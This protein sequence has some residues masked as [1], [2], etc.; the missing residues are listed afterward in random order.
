MSIDGPLD[1]GYANRTTMEGRPANVEVVGRLRLDAALWTPP[2]P[3]RPGQNGRPRKRG[4]RLLTPQ[5]QAAGRTRRGTWHRLRVGL[6]GR[7][8]TPLV[9]GG[10]ALW[11]G[12]LRAQP[13]RFVVVRDPGG[14]RKDEA[15]FCTDRSVGAAFILETY[16][17]RWGLEVAFFDLKQSLGFED[18]QNQTAQAVRRTAPFAGLIQATVVLWAA[19]RVHDGVAPAWPDRPWY[20]RKATPSFP[21]L[22]AALRQA[23]TAQVVRPAAT[24]RLSAAL[25]PTRRHQKPAAG[26]IPPIRAP[27]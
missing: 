15:F 5:A 13:V 1:G 4:T 16:A 3:R 24:P 11:Y 7:A 25:C 12:A 18:P 23:G 27:A 6:Y 19:Q 26:R 22:L 14:R 2:P 9:F 8:V 20:R 17:K 21:D 10:S